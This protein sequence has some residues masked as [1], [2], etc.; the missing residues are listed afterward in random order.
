MKN[1]KI[2]VLGGIGPESS[3]VFYQ[4]LVKRLQIEETIKSNQDFP[5]ILINS[6]PAPELIFDN[7]SKEDLNSYIKGLMELESANPDFMVM[8]C[9]TIHFFHRELQSRITVPILDLREKV[10]KHLS[11]KK[12]PHLTVFG[13]PITIKNDLFALQGTSN[14]MLEE[15][16]INMLSM[17]IS[18]F[19][20]GKDR[21]FQINL[22]KEMAKKHSRNGSVLVACTELSVMLEKFN[23]NKVDTMDILV[24][25]T[26]EEWRNRTNP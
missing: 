12:I 25:A 21:E 2:G 6:I 20:S 10:M 26:I 11:S 24:E 5:T 1:V 3:A 7:H 18:N 14:N 16:E 8:A 9:N 17:A 15:I 22:V 13:T 19:I 4:R 23:M